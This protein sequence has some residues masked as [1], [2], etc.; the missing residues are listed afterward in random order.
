MNG[1]AETDPVA[2][3]KRRRTRPA[4][5]R[6]TRD[7]APL[8]SFAAAAATRDFRG[9]ARAVRRARSAGWP[10]AAVE[11]VALMLILHAGFP[12]A[13]E[14]MSVLQATWPGRARATGARSPK[15]WHARGARVCARVYGRSFPKLVANVRALHPD[16]AGLMV[17]IGYGRVLSRPRLDG[18]SRELAAVAVLAALGWERQLVSHLKGAR[19]FGATPAEVRQAARI[20]A[21]A[22]GAAVR[23]AHAGALA[24]AFGRPQRTG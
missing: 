10:R 6:R 5:R 19:R 8:F 3:P 2:A 21:G 18:Q 20:G 22:G 7:R 17:E 11:E 23:A 16:L 1:A 15:A 24:T 13:L 12:A 9:A 4:M 14:T